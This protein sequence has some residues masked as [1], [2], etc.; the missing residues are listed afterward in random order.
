MSN[1]PCPGIGQGQVPPATNLDLPLSPLNG[2]NYDRKA[3]SNANPSLIDRRDLDRSDGQLV[4]DCRAKEPTAFGLLFERWFDRVFNVAYN[5]VRDQDTASEVAQD[6]FLVMWQ[7]LDRLQDPEAFGGWALRIA[8][9]RGLNRLGKEQRSRPMGAEV[10][11]GL[12]DRTDR[13]DLVGSNRQTQTEAISDSRANQELLWAVSS[14]LG[15]RDASLLDLLLRHQL[16]PAEIA[17]ELDTTAN[18]AH[19][20]LF[21]LRTKLATVVSNYLLW[22][23]GDPR[24]A[25]LRSVLTESDFDA[26]VSKVIQKHAKA[27]TQC[28]EQR[29]S[30]VDPSKL[31]S[32]VPLVAVPLAL[33]TRAAAALQE[34]GVVMDGVQTSP[35]P[36]SPQSAEP[37]AGDATPERTAQ[38]D[39]TGS[40][41]GPPRRRRRMSTLLGAVGLI[42]VATS[43]LLVLSDRPAGEII[44]T[45]GAA[46]DVSTTA[47][48]SLSST[49][50]STELPA[51]T[52]TS[53][54]RS[55]TTPASTQ[56]PASTEPPTTASPTTA[57]PTTASPTTSTPPVTDPGGSEPPADPLPTIRLFRI[58]DPQGIVLTCLT[59]GEIGRRAT[60]T[61]E[62]ATAISL[63]TPG[64]TFVGGESGQQLFCAPTG[65]TITLTV[66][67]PGGSTSDT[68]PA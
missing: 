36:Q 18:N 66:T 41:A 19:Q 4:L 53:T 48:G 17:V 67:G 49:P 5:I 63:S 57:S 3:M 68:R 26:K 20:L 34:A 29:S 15:Q 52:S 43:V 44:T 24:C 56:A 27:C 16:S 55:T 40:S 37:G 51:T 35:S 11:T 31:F 1:D 58:S 6:T 8:R 2:P 54:E 47:L 14:A 38:A 64:E 12:H 30:A 65:A 60:W 25:A 10:M 13:D 50:S 28:A 21:R 32:S 33:R 23:N 22:R 39:E 7:Q 59:P 46:P 42:V 62:G 45:S 9:N 61:T